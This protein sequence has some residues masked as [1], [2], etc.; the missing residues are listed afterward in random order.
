LDAIAHARA[1]GAGGVV[2][3]APAGVGKSRIARESLTVAERQGAVVAWVQATGS[4]ATIPLG[5]FAGVIPAEV[6]SD[7]L[8]ELLQMATAAIRERSGGRRL[9]VGV[10][11]GQLL[12]PVS[13][14][15]VLRLVSSAAA[16]VVA[17]VRSEEPCPDAIEAL[18]KDRLVPRVDVRLLGEEQTGRLVEAILG[19]PAEEAVRQWVWKASEGNALYVRELLFGAIA[20]GALSEVGGL[21]RMPV[22]PPISSS[23]VD[24]IS[25]HLAGLGPEQKHLLELLALGE[26]LLVSEVVRA[27]GREAVA[28]AEE[29]G[30]IRAEG[31]R[32]QDLEVQLSHSL[33]GDSIRARL[34]AIRRHEVLVELA[35]IV[36]SRDDLTPDM[37]L[38]VA[39]WLMD[40]GEAVPT[41][42]LLEAAMAANVRGDPQLGGELAEA[43][44]GA[45][46]GV[47]AV[48]VLA[49]SHAMRDQFEQAETALA[50][51]EPQIKD[52]KTALRYLEQRVMVLFWGLHRTEAMEEV[53]ARAETWWSDADWRTQLAPT[54]LI[55]ASYSSGSTGDL[56]AILAE[57]SELIRS[58]TTDPDVR[59]RLEYVQLATLYRTGRGREADEV[60]QRTRPSLPLRDAQDEATLS[61]CVTIT[62]ETGEGLH[63]IDDW[64]PEVLRNAV[65]IGDRAAAG[66][67]AWALA[68]RR[69]LQGR[70]VDAN[71]WLAE[72][73]LQ[74]EQ[75]DP[76][77][78]ACGVHA[79]QTLV[80][81]DRKD[82]AA[83]EAALAACQA[84]LRGGRVPPLRARSLVYAQAWA[85]S[86]GGDRSRAQSVLLE[87]VPQFRHG[88]PL[89][90]ARLL[91][92]ALRVGA[93]PAT[94]APQLKAISERCDA[95]LVAA[96]AGHATHLA[97]RD[98]R[99]LLET[100][101]LFERVGAPVYGCE[102]AADAA[103]LFLSI[104]RQDSARRAAARRRELFV[105]GQGKPIPPVPGL[106]GEVEL[107]RRE[108]QLLELASRGLTHRQI[109]EQLVLSIR[110]VESHLYRVRQKLGGG[111]E[112]GHRPRVGDGRG[113]GV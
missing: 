11:D 93:P 63:Q 33:Y 5:A 83:A 61:L 26:P 104:G 27:V 102:A 76:G 77:G 55:V 74:F 69:I 34:G 10:D 1:D 70:Y 25:A 12:D 95:S 92:E 49:R 2:L 6:R 9:V 46:A 103:K 105:E 53:L 18:W 89:H 57:S 36:Q 17:T 37:S 78:L 40:A 81:A 39:R 50:E 47:E 58:G 79:L 84:A 19:G 111:I 90:A 65:R 45:G 13:A 35:Q 66:L 48:L 14:A 112:D 43:A 101:D 97:A 82:F 67:A 86:A 64:A 54:R 30:L 80:A 68:H 110:T 21:W 29:G 16:F 42:I 107:T 85:A 52:Q 41:P 108:A 51:I 22:R 3:Y 59:R 60:A 96:T 100:V 31:E 44:V 62:A 8:L 88:F 72:A 71:R 56:S 73:Q 99:A 23:L 75:H 94:I 91:Y 113:D 98:P 20:A 32:H 87:A 4:A 24:S 38:R 7:S 15:L 28:A 106:D 109:A